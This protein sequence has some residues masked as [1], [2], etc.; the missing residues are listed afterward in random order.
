MKYFEPF[1]KIGFQLPHLNGEIFENSHCIKMNGDSLSKNLIEQCKS[2][3]LNFSEKPKLAVILVGDDEASHIYVNRKIKSCF[4]VG[5]QSVPYFFKSHEITQSQLIQRIQKLND[6]RTI[7]GILVQLPLPSHI[8]SKNIIHS[9]SPHKDVDGFTV[10]N[11][12]KLMIDNVTPPLP[13]TPLGI[14]LLLYSYRISISK[15]N[16]VVIG[17]SQI[18]GRPA[19]MMMM[20]ENATVTYCHSWTEN[21]DLITSQADILITAMG[22]SNFIQSSMLKEKSIIIDVGI[23]RNSEG[24]LN[25]DVHKNAILKAGY[26]TPVPGGVGPMTI[27]CLLMNTV[28]LKRF[29]KI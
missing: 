7:T 24:K 20:H 15:K 8:N 16:V 1:S 14:L 26:L 2:I 5:I 27:A 19:G 21:L 10:Q 28:Y 29:E 25:G 6:D 12:G 18:V 23:H 4:N 9:I 22:K 11:Q 17:R 3:V 13:C